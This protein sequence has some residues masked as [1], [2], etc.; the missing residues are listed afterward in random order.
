MAINQLQRL[1]IGILYQQGL[2]V[3]KIAL[4]THF[5]QPTINR[6]VNRLKLKK[7]GRPV[8]KSTIENQIVS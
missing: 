7:R 8:K 5:S 6:A 1:N 4:K 2:S 3:R